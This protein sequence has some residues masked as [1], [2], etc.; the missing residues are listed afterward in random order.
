MFTAAQLFRGARVLDFGCATGWL[1]RMLASMG[2]HATGTD[3]SR[4]ALGSADRFARRHHPELLERLEWKLFDGSRL[5]LP[6]ASM[7]R[8]L[9][10]DVFHHVPNQLEVL[11]EFRRVLRPDGLAVFSEPGPN[12]SRSPGAQQEMREFGVIEND[13]IAEEIEAHALAAGFERVALSL[14]STA[15]VLLPVTDYLAMERAERPGTPGPPNETFRRALWP[16][17]NGVRAFVMYASPLA[18]KP[19]S[20]TPAHCQGEVT[21]LEHRAEAGGQRLR[22]RVANTSA[23]WWVPSGAAAGAVNLAL[24]LVRDGRVVEFAVAR[25]K[26]LDAPLLPGGVVETEML[27]P[28]PAPPGHSYRLGLVAEL[29]TWFPLPEQALA[30]PE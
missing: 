25:Q 26:F 2:C 9:C 1:T 18:G 19:S 30:V 3:V 14:F 13:M 23:A 6:D 15:P 17:L 4:I 21:L 24:H 10:H 16:S 8:I 20:R 28:H 12:H 22:L 7:D 27:V 11:R 5:D 29:V